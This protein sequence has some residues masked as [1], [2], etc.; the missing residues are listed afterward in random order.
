MKYTILGFSQQ[1][2]LNLGLGMDEAMI[3]RWFVDFQGTGKMRPVIHDG[4]TWLWVN[5]SGV[6]EDLPIVGGSAKTISRR[7]E[8]LVDSGVLEHVT[9]KEGGVFSCFRLCESVYTRLV[10]DEEIQEHKEENV[11]LDKS[12]QPKTEVSDHWTNLSEQKTL[13][14][15]TNTPLENINILF[16]PTGE[17]PPKKAKRQQFVKPTL[18]EVQSYC[19]ERGGKVNP[20]KWFSHYEANGWRVGRNPMKDWKAAVRTWEHGNFDKKPEADK[21]R[22]GRVNDLWA[23]KKSG[24]V[25]L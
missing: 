24:K 9:I 7:F 11:G 6:L 3:L 10:D 14:L 1:H 20:E 12:V 15:D 2:L 5:Y 4:K 23:G 16:P 17:K 21:F 19:Q 18:S 8:R 13:L 25:T 22:S